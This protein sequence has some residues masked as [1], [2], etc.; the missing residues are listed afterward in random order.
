MKFLI[1]LSADCSSL[2]ETLQALK[3]HGHEVG[4]LLAQD[5]VFLADKGCPESEEIDIEGVKVYVSRPH[6]EQRGIG[7]RLV[8]DFELVDYPEIVDL[9]MDRYDR[10]ICF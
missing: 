10:V 2:D 7:D 3:K 8:A 4:I 1:W 5:G 6:V 9:V